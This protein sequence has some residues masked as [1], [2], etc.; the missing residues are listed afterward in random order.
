MGRK[1]TVEM[2]GEERHAFLEEHSV[3]TLST[4]GKDAGRDPALLRLAREAHQWAHERLEAA[5]RHLGAGRTTDARHALED[6]QDQM[7]G[8]T[9]EAD[10]RRGLEAI[11]FGED[12]AFL[13]E[14]SAVRRA[15]RRSAYERLRGSR[16]AKLFRE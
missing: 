1:S 16:W 8:Q 6:V 2:T 12:L 7:A 9:E 15:V 13:S 5:V 11:E 14:S 10:V 3:L 4:I